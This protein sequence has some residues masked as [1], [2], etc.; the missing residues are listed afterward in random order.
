M[1]QVADRAREMVRNEG[2]SLKLEKH[3][4]PLWFVGTDL[5]CAVGHF[6]HHAAIEFWRGSTL[7]DP[8]HLLEGT[9]K[10]LRHVKLRTLEDASSPELRRLIRAAIELDRTAPK[11]AR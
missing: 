10:N 5:I 8:D 7:P 6:A 9:G 2:P 4:E 3:W 1:Q 11:R